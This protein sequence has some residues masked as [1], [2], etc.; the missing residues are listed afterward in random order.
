LSHDLR[1]GQP[2]PLPAW[3]HYQRALSRAEPLVLLQD[4]P[5][6]SAEERRAL[7]L[8]Q[9]RSLCLAPLRVGGEDAGVLVLGEARSPAREPFAAD[10]LRFTVSLAD[11]AASAL[12]RTRLHAELEAAYLETVL[13]LAKAMDARDTYTGDHSQRLV[14]WGEATARELGC[15][16]AE[17]EAI[18]WG[19][20]L[21]DIGK[22]GVPDAILLKPEPLDE[23]EW[24]VMHR[25]PEIGAEIVAPMTKLA[26]VVPII[27]AHH[28]KWDGTGYPDRLRGEAIPLGARVLA[29]VDA[30]GAITDDRLYRQG[31]S[32]AEAVAELRHCMGTHFDPQ[33][34]EAFLRVIGE[35]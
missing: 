31:R 13:A 35:V 28:E 4:D 29:V 1:V 12:Y 6:L 7:F 11:Q 34:V 26:D 27:R 10:K 16:E 24:A 32:H 30:Y 14:A 33:V 22:I 8:D 25:H 19:A 17:V 2:E 3:S 15:S 18:R 5:A 20:L 21:H 23:V 9:V